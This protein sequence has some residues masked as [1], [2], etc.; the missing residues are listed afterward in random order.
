MIYSWTYKEISEMT[1]SE[2]REC[3]NFTEQRL[4]HYRRLKSLGYDSYEVNP[5]IKNLGSRK[6]NLKE[7]IKIAKQT[8]KK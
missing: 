7:A 3:L 5:K 4:L 1:L 8:V 6:K 2:L